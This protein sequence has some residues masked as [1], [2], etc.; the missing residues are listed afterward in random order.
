MVDDKELDVM[1]LDD[2]I[3]PGSKSAVAMMAVLAHVA[4]GGSVVIMTPELG[5]RQVIKPDAKGIA[6][7]RDLI[8]VLRREEVLPVGSGLAA[9]LDISSLQG[10]NGRSFKKAEREDR[11]PWYARHAKG[12]RR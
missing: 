2:V 6:E 8:A 1:I 10:L 11:K 4:A 3:R 12:K 7:A 5:G 9:S